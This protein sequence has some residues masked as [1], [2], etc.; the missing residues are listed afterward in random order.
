MLGL[1]W[2]SNCCVSNPFCGIVILLR[3]DVI[4]DRAV[5]N[6]VAAA[7]VFPVQCKCAMSVSH[8]SAASVNGFVMLVICDSEVIVFASIICLIIVLEASCRE[9]W[10]VCIWCCVK[11]AM[12]VFL[13]GSGLTLE[14]HA[15]KP[16]DDN[17]N[18]TIISNRAGFSIVIS[19]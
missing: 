5:R 4:D 19:T 3:V 18:P 12:F 6:L 13:L 10:S 2:F 7:A 17:T 15:A 1:I 9:V 14:T 16:I 11:M 8:R